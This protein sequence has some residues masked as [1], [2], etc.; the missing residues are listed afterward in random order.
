[1]SA[2]I[3]L[4]DSSSQSLKLK[5]GYT[6]SI[7]SACLLL[8]HSSALLKSLKIFYE[9]GYKIIFFP[10]RKFPCEKEWVNYDKI[11]QKT[12]QSTI[13]LYSFGN[14]NEDEFI[15]FQNY[16]IS[17]FNSITFL[18]FSRI[19]LLYFRRKSV[20]HEGNVPIFTQKSS[21]YSTA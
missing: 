10:K 17:P 2:I 4:K 1:M 14:K 9:N 20:S 5:K 12:L 3:L 21:W 8:S 13:L 6:Q 16:V 19:F 11:I 18:Y 15:K 7:M